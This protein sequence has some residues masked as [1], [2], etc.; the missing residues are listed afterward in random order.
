MTFDFLEPAQAELNEAFQFYEAQREGLGDEFARE[1]FRTIQRILNHP[2]A[3]AR[4]SKQSRRCRTKRFPYGIIY[5]IREEEKRVL[6]IAVM[7][8]SRKPGYWKPRL[9]G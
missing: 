9:R 5:Q 1:V 2:H 4:L 3:W 6:I 8:L 7:H